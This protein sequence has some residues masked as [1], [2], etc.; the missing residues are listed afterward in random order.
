MN[1]DITKIVVAVIGLCVLAITTFL[2]PY[3]R[4]KYGQE[5]INQAL[6]TADTIKNVAIMAAKMVE[7]MFPGESEKKLQEAMNWAENYLNNLGLTVDMSVLRGAIEAAVLDINDALTNATSAS[8]DAISISTKSD[9]TVPEAIGTTEES[10]DM[11]ADAE[12]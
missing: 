11:S 7:Q 4:K 12:G 2:I 5:K 9:G 3:L 1:T 10:E 6:A 8:V